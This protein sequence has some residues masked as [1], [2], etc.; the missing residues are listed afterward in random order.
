MECL[1]DAVTLV[2]HL[3][4]LPGELPECQLEQNLP[5][6]LQIVPAG[7]FVTPHGVQ[8]GV[9]GS[10]RHELPVFEGHVFAVGLALLRTESEV[11]Q[12]DPFVHVL[13]EGHHHVFGFEVLV[14]LVAAVQLAEG[15]EQRE[16]Q[17]AEGLVRKLV[18]T[19]VV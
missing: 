11:D 4:A 19:E 3:Q 9:A 14:D 16:A 17:V 5:E 18:V 6:T 1:H 15:V 7:V 2:F 10:A 12:L 13:V 8:T